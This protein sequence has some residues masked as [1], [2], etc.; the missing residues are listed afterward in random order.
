MLT[1]YVRDVGADAAGAAAAI[2]LAGLGGITKA[3]ADGYY[4]A[5]GAAAAITLAGLGGITKAAADG[6]Y[7]ALGAA[8]AVTLSG[9][10]GVPTGRTINGYDLTA[11]RSLTYSD[12]GADV[13][14]AAAAITLSGLG[15]VPSTRKIT[16]TIDLSADRNLTYSDVGAD[17][18]GAAATVA[19]NL[20][21]HANLTT[22]HGSTNANTASTIVQRDASGNFSAGTITAA[23][24]GGAT[25][26][27]F[28]STVGSADEV[29]SAFTHYPLISV[30]GSPISI[31]T[32]TTKLS[33]VPSTGILTASGFSGPL[34]GNVTGNCSGSAGSCTGNA[35]NVTGTV[36]VGNG[37]TGLTTL[38]ASYIPYGAGTSAL[39]STADLTWVAAT[40][41]LGVGLSSGGHVIFYGDLIVQGY[42]GTNFSVSDTNATTGGKSTFSHSGTTFNMNQYNAGGTYIGTPMQITNGTGVKFAAF[43]C[44]GKTPQTAYASGGAAGGTATSGGYGFVSAAEMNAFVTL[45][46]NVRLALVANGVM[47]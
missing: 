23:L 32:S 44:N 6:Y 42:G 12:V 38:A 5:L 18:S 2:T 24:N 28:A 39:A 25:S 36:A 20:T 14:G 17:A 26:A 47:S 8:A 27:V 45:L 33:F 19:G 29:V 30:G 46:T 41:T 1:G 3:A 4:D 40:K 10:G 35:A 15:G 21:T 13:A 34:T 43:S 9:L 37:G 22:A 11:N 31:K 7:D 16:S